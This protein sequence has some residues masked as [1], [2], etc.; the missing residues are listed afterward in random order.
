MKM[1]MTLMTMM[2]MVEFIDRMMMD[3]G[4]SGGMASPPGGV[5]RMPNASDMMM[6]AM[7]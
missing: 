6:K 2:L 5:M 4:D 3:R 1:M 7:P